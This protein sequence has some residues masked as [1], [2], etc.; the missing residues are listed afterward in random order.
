MICDVSPSQPGSMARDPHAEAV[1][2]LAAL[3]HPLR[4]R[5]VR[6]LADSPDEALTARSLAESYGV[7][8]DTMAMHLSQ[9]T[10]AGLIRAERNAGQVVHV[11]QA[12]V[13]DAVARYVGE[14]C[15]LAEG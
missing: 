14:R 8:G 3:A 11:R 13:V 2:A 12:A 15:A 4:L 10:R 7:D 1:Q 5:L 6:H 9:L